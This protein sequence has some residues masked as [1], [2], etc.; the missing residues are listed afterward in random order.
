MEIKKLV[1]P[2]QLA[3]NLCEGYGIVEVREKG[4]LDVLE[5]CIKCH[6]TGLR[7]FPESTK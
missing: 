6:A 2:K 3:C 7:I 1:I 4:K 5:R